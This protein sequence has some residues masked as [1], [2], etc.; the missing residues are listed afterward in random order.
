MNHDELPRLKSAVGNDASMWVLSDQ[1]SGVRVSMLRVDSEG[2]W[3][4]MLTGSGPRKMVFSTFAVA[5]DMPSV[6]HMSLA[7][8]IVEKTQD[9][10]S[11]CVPVS[12]S[13]MR[14][15]MRETYIDSVNGE[16][17][18]HPTSHNW[19]D[20]E[21]SLDSLQSGSTATLPGHLGG[22][23]QHYKTGSHANF[24]GRVPTGGSPNRGKTWGTASR[25]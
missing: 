18:D 5:R 3:F 1:L 17:R 7:S 22:F 10:L 25:H 21:T 11:V 4:G 12:L 15:T 2:C 9:S 13:S 19:Q 24:Q 8:N 16:V 6:R 20:R 23:P 14:V